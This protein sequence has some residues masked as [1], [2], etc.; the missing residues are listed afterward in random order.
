MWFL[1]LVGFLSMFI[2]TTSNSWVLVLLKYYV[3]VSTVAIKKRSRVP[4]VIITQ[5]VEILPA[6]KTTPDFTRKPMATTV[7]E[8]KKKKKVVILWLQQHCQTIFTTV[9]LLCDLIFLFLGKKA[10]FKAMVNGE[11]APTVTWERKK[12]NVSDPEKYKTRYDER[13]REHILEVRKQY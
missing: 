1:F 4:G 3:L 7:L 2:F 10:F 6:G 5:Y 9:S 12:G 8:G 13:A 11:P